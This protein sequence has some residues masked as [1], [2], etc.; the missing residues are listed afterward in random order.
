MHV[1]YVHVFEVSPCAVVNHV[2]AVSDNAVVVKCVAMVVDSNIPPAAR[3]M[4]SPN[5]ALTQHHSTQY[6]RETTHMYI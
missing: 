2:V 3:S 4:R 6:G 1:L 5:T